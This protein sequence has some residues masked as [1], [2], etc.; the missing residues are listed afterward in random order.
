V[1]A[2]ARSEVRRQGKV[3]ERLA[4]CGAKEAEAVPQPARAS[5]NAEAESLG[6]DVVDAFAAARDVIARCVVIPARA[7]RITAARLLDRSRVKASRA[8]KEANFE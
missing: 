1:E 7:A 6:D 2:F 5:G 3:E 8:S 4:I